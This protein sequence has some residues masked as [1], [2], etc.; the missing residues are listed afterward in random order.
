MVP[1]RTHARAN[2]A[3]GLA[4]IATAV[5]VGFFVLRNGW[6]QSL[7]VGAD[8][9]TE[10]P[11]GGEDNAAPPSSET[12]ASTVPLRPPAEVTVRVLNAAGV[13]GAAGEWTTTLTEA[14]YPTVEPDNA[15]GQETR[16]TTAVLFA[17]GFDRE[18]AEVARQIGSPADQITPLGDP[19]TV[20][21]AQAQIVVMLGTDLAEAAPG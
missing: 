5:I 7:P 8:T 1:E 17:A 10:A 6:D 9:G 16:D 18:A 14:G 11:A 21:P 2:P 19:P 15:P 3:R 12:T 4:L 20:D 13:S